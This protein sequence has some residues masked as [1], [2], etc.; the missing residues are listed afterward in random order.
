MSILPVRGLAAKG[1]IRDANAYDLDLNAWSDG[2]NVFFNNGKAQ[3]APIW[4]TVYDALSLAPQFVTALRNGSGSADTVFV[5]NADGSSST[6][7]GG[8]KTDV[9]DI[10]HVSNVSTTAWTSTTHGQVLYLNRPDAVPRY[11]GPSSTR[12]AVL[13]NWDS[14]WRCR[15]MR[16]FQ[17]YIIALNV[18]KGATLIP[19]MVKWSDLTLAGQVPG[20]WDA[21]DATKNTGE[22]VLG[23]IDSP[24]VDGLP[25]FNTFYIYSSTQTWAMEPT[26]NQLIFGFRRVFNDGGMIAPGCV[27]EVDGKHYV[28]GT[29]DIYMHDGNTKQSLVQSRNRDA[30]FRYLDTTLTERCFVQ[31]VPQYRCIVFG[32]VSGDPTCT[33]QQP[34]GCN[35]AAVYDLTND[36]WTFVDLPN[37]FGGVYASV[38]TQPTWTSLGSTTW[39]AQGGSWFDMRA[40][41]DRHLIVVSQ[42]QTALG[43]TAHRLLGWDFVNKGSMTLPYVAE[44]NASAFLLRTGVDLDQIGADLTTYKMVRRLYP[45]ANMFAS[46]PIYMQFGS[47][48]T[49]QG[50][51]VWTPEAPYDPTQS[52][53]VDFRRGGRYLAAKFTV[54]SIVDFELSGFDID[55]TSAGRR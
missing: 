53:K 39:T 9:T 17:D 48:L 15:S 23:D 35:K 54:H 34:T 7:I 52:Y 24:I 16:T 5:V 55:V 44:V 30:V 22:N 12:L 4:R 28:F 3:R 50:P 41:L 32:Y 13:P 46:A 37:V 20:S 33:W 49:S 8:V 6:V 1:I 2:S 10:G 31:F 18:T 38:S 43:I 21:T 11:W 26:G 36:T 29:D 42:Q 25:L 27:A 19:E 47:S 45:M 40:G 14:T 51:I